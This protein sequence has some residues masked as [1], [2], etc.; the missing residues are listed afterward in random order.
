MYKESLSIVLLV[1]F[2]TILL[3]K[4][5]LRL[6][7]TGCR[8]GRKLCFG[9]N[10]RFKKLLLNEYIEIDKIMKSRQI[11]GFL[12]SGTILGYV[13]HNDL[14]PNDDDISIHYIC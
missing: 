10:N 5:I 8:M 11:K 2:G 6:K 14:I 7:P 13:R 12:S 9:N 3:I 1:I 4:I